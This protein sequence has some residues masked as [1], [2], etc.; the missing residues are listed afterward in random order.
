MKRRA[1]FTILGGAAAC[2]LAVRAMDRVRGKFGHEA[3]VKG[4]AL[5]EDN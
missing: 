4:L 1:F 3:V 2:P 5:E